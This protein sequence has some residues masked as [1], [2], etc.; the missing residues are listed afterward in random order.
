MANS[1]DD[2]L[3]LEWCEILRLIDDHELI[4]DAAPPDITQRL[5]H[6]AA[7]AHQVPAAAVFMAHVQVA[8]HL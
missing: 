4:G 3:G 8:E 5:N 1:C 2:R 6:D 7:G